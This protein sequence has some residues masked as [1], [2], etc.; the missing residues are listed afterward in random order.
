[1]RCFSNLE[2]LK[3]VKENPIKK[4]T[5]DYAKQW[6]LLIKS[7]R[8]SIRTDQRAPKTEKTFQ[9]MDFISLIK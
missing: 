5:T 4:S 8:W 3:G 9:K 6:M 2:I 7:S 1:M